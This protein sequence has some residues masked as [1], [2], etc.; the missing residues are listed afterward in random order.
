[1]NLNIS[2][3]H[4]LIMFINEIILFTTEAEAA[5]FLSFT[6]FISFTTITILTVITVK[7]Y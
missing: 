2:Q 3:S 5:Y 1:M 6:Y 7:R 4:P